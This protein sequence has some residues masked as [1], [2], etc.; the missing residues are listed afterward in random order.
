MDFTLKITL[1]PG[2]RNILTIKNAPAKNLQEREFLVCRDD[3]VLALV[4][5]LPVHTP[6]KGQ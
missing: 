1:P 5:L 4:R 2:V 3:G 6:S